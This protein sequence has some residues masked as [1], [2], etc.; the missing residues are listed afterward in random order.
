MKS[1][2]PSSAIRITGDLARGLT[3]VGLNEYCEKVKQA[4]RECGIKEMGELELEA[5]SLDKEFDIKFELRDYSKA[6]CM[7][8][9]I[10]RVLPSMPGTTR[11]VFEQIL[12]QLANE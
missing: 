6:D 12:I 1:E 8:E 11:A 10:R 3:V 2:G 9:A 4:A 5:V 7:K